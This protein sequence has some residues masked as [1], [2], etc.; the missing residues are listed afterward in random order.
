[1]RIL[2]ITN[3]YP[4]PFEP[5]RG[6]FNGEQLRALAARCPVRLIS[7]IAWTEE[8]ASRARGRPGLP[9]GRRLSRD[10][11]VVDHPRY[12]Y[13]PRVLRGRYGHFYRRSIR[14]S[15]ERAL[16]E[17]RPDL[18]FATWAYPDGWAA[19]DL[20]RRAGLPAVVKVHGCDVLYGLRN[21]PSKR[22]G[23]GE[24]LRGADA[25]V[26]VSRDLAEK[27]IEFGVSPSRVEVVYNGIDASLFHPAP[28][29][30]ARARLGLGEQD[31]LILCVANLFAV[32]GV[33]VLIGACA[34]L[35]ARGLPF[36]TCVI[37]EGPLRP[38]LQQQIDSLGLAGT[39]ELLGA[40]PHDRL[41]D[42]Y[43]ATSVLAVPSR[44]E[45]VPCVLLEGIACGA[46]FVASRVG[47]VPEI[48]HRGEGR[49]VP[50]D[51]AERLAEALR[52]S[53]AESA[54]GGAPPAR[55]ARG[56]AEAAGEL[57]A[58]FERVLA[59]KEDRRPVAV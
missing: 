9:A 2:A 38:Q 27:V 13:P 4:N 52:E 40:R 46:P 7:P 16:A 54:R 14:A 22:R 43:R 56:H 44:S 37:G 20:A 51:D 1:M 42:W 45:G 15:F 26:A 5:L 55:T 41:P 33:D 32:K 30:P 53:L 47:G 24:A 48:A 58:V 36:K 34:R 23:T 6:L 50:P 17:F 57:M 18:V 59:L 49:L 31:P 3:L 35:A 28:R 19:V 12:L 10:G 21:T 25:V 39:V 29:G 11:I 8:L